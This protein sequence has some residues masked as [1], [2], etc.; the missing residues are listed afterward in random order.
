M[1]M[2]PTTTS[3]TLLGARGMGFVTKEM[4][5]TARDQASSERHSQP[6]GLRPAKEIEHQEQ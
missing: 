1:Q 6:G 2:Q 3:T 5:D 4:R